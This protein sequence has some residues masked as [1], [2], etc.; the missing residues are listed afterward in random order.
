MKFT[1][2]KSIFKAFQG[3]K[4][5]IILAKN[6]DNLIKEDGF[7]ELIKQKEE[8]LDQ[9]LDI[10]TLSEHTQIKPW[11]EAYSKFGAKP[12][13][14]KSSVEALLIRILEGNSIP[15]INPLV[16]AYNFISISHM[17]PLGGDDLDCVEGDIKLTFARGDEKYVEINSKNSEDIKSPDK[18]EV[19]Y[20][21]NKDILCRRWNWREADKTKISDTTR[22]VILYIEG[23]DEEKV[24]NATE[25]LK[26]IIKEHFTTFVRDFYLD[27][28]KNCLE[29]NKELLGT[30][31]S[32]D[33]DSELGQEIIHK[34]QEEHKMKKEE[35]LKES[36]KSTNNVNQINDKVL[37]EDPVFHWADVAAKRIIHDKGNKNKYTCAAGITP[38]GT[39]H[40]GNFREIITTDLVVRALRD[41][42]KEV[43]F[44]YSWDD[45]DVFR[46]VP[47]NMPNQEMLEKYMR[48]SIVD[49]PDPFGTEDN[50]AKHHEVEIEKDCSKV[51]ILP[52]FL[53]QAKKYRNL[54]YVKGIITALKNKDLIVKILNKHKTEDVSSDWMPISGY[55]PNCNKDKVSFC[56]YKN[57]SFITMKCEVCNEESEIDI[58]KSPFIKLPWRVDWP[59]R[60]AHEK[61]D[62]EPGGK[63]HSS[64]SGSYD[65]GKEI[66]SIFNWTAPSYVMYDFVK[67][68]GADKKISSSSGDVI[69]LKDFLEIYTPEIVRYIFAGTRPNKELS[70][71]FDGDVI[72]VYDD[73]DKCERMYYEKIEASEKD[74]IK[75]KRI[76]ELS[77]I[78]KPCKKM[79][80]QV[81][82]GECA[83]LIQIL[84]NVDSSIQR[85][86][87]KGDIPEDA[88]KDEIKYVTD[89][90]NL[91]KTWIS[92]FAPDQ[93]VF[94][95]NTEI[96]SN[97]QLSEKQK[98]ALKEVL[99]NLKETKF[100][101]YAPLH[102]LFKEI[103]AEYHMETSE[104]FSGSYRVLISK[105]RGPQLA[106]FIL[107][108]GQD[109]V[110]ELLEK[111]K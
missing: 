8:E 51:G 41:L 91:A 59:M 62:F 94:K 104:F 93:Y 20:K 6:V 19:I 11:R 101:N 99:L 65:T 95:L 21:D 37:D 108:I 1:I 85:F 72:K 79:P 15:A 107:M 31:I 44:I 24:R 92:K 48:H 7:I 43:R 50:Y 25:Q 105:E 88:T 96:P 54:E 18:N 69:T 52:E 90:I 78:K 53:Y 28:N 68:K 106:N 84:G 49:I 109:K 77:L 86:K 9:T 10:N 40:I 81:S 89:R 35:K 38:S 16:D 30:L 83:N 34:N 12:K 46:K 22:N 57:D 26:N 5:G 27:K 102:D 98:K 60:W 71:A 45:Y 4:I 47:K 58:R 23:F 110:I 66:V 36:F 74:K 14:H 33:E 64:A 39:V 56:N 2:S 70:I 75:N 63:D 29:F 73:F 100:D 17:L 55:C 67:I 97:I 42:G 111:L 80:L 32:S 3:F 61:V 82:F 13:K 76:Y 87:E 103:I